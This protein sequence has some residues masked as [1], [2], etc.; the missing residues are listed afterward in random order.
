[1]TQGTCTGIN[2]ICT[3]IN[4]ICTATNGACQVVGATTSVPAVSEYS[5][6]LFNDSKAVATT[7][8]PFLD[9]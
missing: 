7:Y 5:Y 4:G 3:G 9:F 2:G 6:S 1:V 8:D